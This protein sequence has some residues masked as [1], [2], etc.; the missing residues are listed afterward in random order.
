MRIIFSKAYQEKGSLKDEAFS[1][2]EEKEEEELERSSSTMIARG[3]LLLFGDG[4]EAIASTR[5][6]LVSLKEAPRDQPPRD[7]TYEEHE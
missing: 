1:I 3:Y 4:G 6:A 7:L 2:D 5:R